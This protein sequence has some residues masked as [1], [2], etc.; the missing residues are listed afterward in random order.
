MLERTEKR[1]SKKRGTGEVVA[2]GWKAMPET[3]ERVE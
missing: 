1:K 3:E 2:T